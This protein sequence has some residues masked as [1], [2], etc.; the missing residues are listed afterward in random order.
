MSEETQK[1]QEKEN[2]KHFMNRKENNPKIGERQKRILEILAETD[3]EM[4]QKEI[5]D[6]LND[7]FY[8]AINQSDIAKD[9]IKLKIQKHPDRKGYIVSDA[10]KRRINVDE[11]VRIAAGANIKKSDIIPDVKMLIIKSNNKG[12]SH[13]LSE[14]LLKMYSDL[15]VTIQHHEN[16]LIIYYRDISIDEKTLPED[17]KSVLP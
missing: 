9:F 7:E 2:C 10:K 4:T 12:H 13:F 1:Y 3:G 6:R 11:L 8:S 17:I 16:N 14:H 15:I 5:L